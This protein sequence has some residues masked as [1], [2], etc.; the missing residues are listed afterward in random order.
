MTSKKHV[1]KALAFVIAVV[2]IPAMALSV[3]VFGEANVLGLELGV[4]KASACSIGYD[5]GCGNDYGCGGGC[6]G[7]N[8]GGYN[9]VQ[10]PN[11]SYVYNQNPVNQ[12][13]GGGYN[14]VQYPNLSYVY[15]QDPSR[16]NAG[17]SYNYVQY[18]SL[19][20]VYYQD[21]SR[22]NAMDD[23]NY[24]YTQYPNLKY[25]YYGQGAQGSQVSGSSQ[26]GV[27]RNSQ[28]QTDWMSVFSNPTQ[29]QY[30][31]A[32]AGYGY[33]MGNVYGMGSGY[34]SGYGTGGGF[35]MVSGF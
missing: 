8:T 19:K 18:P 32:N 14:Y 29:P 9:Y 27:A 28:P 7:Y 5:Y 16:Q 35:T 3:G 31:Y 20:Y 17:S 22:R 2:F 10:Y 6:G 26:N 15:N 11:L 25:V 4:K 13:N 30:N 24:T 21:P 33:G 23:Y 34:N 12:S 1:K